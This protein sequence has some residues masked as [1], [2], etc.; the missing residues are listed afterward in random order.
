MAALG[1]LSSVMGSYSVWGTN[2]NI[3]QSAVLSRPF[4]I[5]T[6]PFSVLCCIVP[7]NDIC[8]LSLP[9][10]EI[11]QQMLDLI[12]AR[13]APCLQQAPVFSFAATLHHYL[14]SAC[15]HWSSDSTSN[16]CGALP[17]T[18][19]YFLGWF[20]RNS[21]HNCKQIAL[22]IFGFGT[23]FVH[24]LLLYILLNLKGEPSQEC[25]CFP[26]TGSLHPLMYIISALC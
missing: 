1:I 2:L 7:Q 22:D 10:G 8:S 23:I 15:P 16:P 4:S 3:F 21:A 6:F 9:R 12:I 13:E 25:S 11:R 17:H 18:E 5:W 20:V 24:V 19:C 14:L 26:L